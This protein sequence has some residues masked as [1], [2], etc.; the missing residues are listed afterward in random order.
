MSEQLFSTQVPRDPDFIDLGIGQ[1]AMDILPRELL[2]EAAAHRLSIAENA[3]LNY[4]PEAGDGF[5]RR[6]L[7][8]FLQPHYG[9]DIPTDT[10]FLTSGSSRALSYI[11]HPFYSAGRHDFCRGANLLFGAIDF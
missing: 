8:N 9:F 7:G 10:L 2:R 11:C 1:P 4:G 5:F 6:T 3:L